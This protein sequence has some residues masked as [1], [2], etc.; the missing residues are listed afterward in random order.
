MINVI[1]IHKCFESA[2][3]PRKVN[4]NL[5]YHPN[6]MPDIDPAALTRTESYSHP[7]APPPLT[8]KLGGLTASTSQKSAKATNAA[9]RVDLEPLYT[10]L[11]AAI[12][13]YWNEYKDAISLF[14]LGEYVVS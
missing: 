1:I 14:M 11:K 7:L 5:V 12:G 4:T 6:R 10:S 3:A 9:Q 13:D 2:D 8:T